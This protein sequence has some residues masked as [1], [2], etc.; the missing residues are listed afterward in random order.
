MVLPFFAS[1]EQ[2]VF[3]HD[4]ARGVEPGK[5]FIHDN[6]FRVVQNRPNKLHLLLHSLGKF[7]D[8][9]SGPR[10]QLETLAPVA[11]ALQSLCAAES[12]E[13]TEK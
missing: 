9:L 12:L 10:A 7:F 3:Q 13:L 6:Q 5:R 8:F 2:N 1:L 11:R 4:R